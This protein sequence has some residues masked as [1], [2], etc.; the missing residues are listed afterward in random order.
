MLILR[1]S[2]TFLLSNYPN[3]HYDMTCDLV[4]PAGCEDDLYSE[5]FPLFNIDFSPLPLD[6]GQLVEVGEGGGGE[7]RRGAR[8]C[9][10][11][12]DV[13]TRNELAWLHQISEA[14]KRQEKQELRR[15]IVGEVGE[16]GLVE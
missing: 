3:Y 14:S 11:R 16:Y 9:R 15:Q 2:N 4:A 6:E 13:S 1:D 5:D 7:R 10:A 12:R 8:R